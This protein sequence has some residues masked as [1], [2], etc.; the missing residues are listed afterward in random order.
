MAKRMGVIDVE[1]SIDTDVIQNITSCM[2]AYEYKNFNGAVLI[3]R[4]ALSYAKKLK[5]LMGREKRNQKYKERIEVKKIAKLL[6]DALNFM[7]KDG[8]WKRLENKHVNKK[9]F[10]KKEL[11]ADEF[12]KMLKEAEGEALKL[13]KLL[14]K[15]G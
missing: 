4:H 7:E 9:R 5:G 10:E 11:E 15:R 13:K 1:I 3:L 2:W 6:D 12:Y 8:R 14:L